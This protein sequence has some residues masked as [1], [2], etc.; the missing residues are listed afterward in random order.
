[1]ILRKAEEIGDMYYSG[2][3]LLS[4]SNVSFAVNPQRMVLSASIAAL[5]FR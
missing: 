2:K 1:M 5:R 3:N 4:V